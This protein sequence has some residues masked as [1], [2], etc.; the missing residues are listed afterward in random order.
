[1]IES[2]GVGWTNTFA[3]CVVWLGCAL[4]LVTIR[5]GDKMRAR[6]TRWE[7]TVL[8]GGAKNRAP[9]GGEE[10]QVG[11]ERSVEK[12]DEDAAGEGVRHTAEGSAL[13]TE[14]SETKT[15]RDAG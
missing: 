15:T 6:G 13:D 2:I 14:R 12:E 5:W 7:G 3:A 8:A 11:L 4:V 9:A 1:M 10:G